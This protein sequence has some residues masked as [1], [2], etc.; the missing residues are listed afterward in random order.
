MDMQTTARAPSC[1]GYAVR[2]RI[3]P[4]H[5]VYGI[6]AHIQSGQPT[7]SFLNAVLRNNLRDAIGRAD[8]EALQALPA[9][10]GWFY[11]EAPAHCWGSPEK[12]SRW[13]EMGG[14]DGGAD[15]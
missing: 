10:V 15:K 4:G 6:D 8:D 12:V 13:Q 5:L 2:G 14:L 1:A 3:I 7:G 11:N 9:I